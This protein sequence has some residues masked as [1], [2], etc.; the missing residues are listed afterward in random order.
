MAV[1]AL[2]GEDEGY[3]K[4]SVGS[5]VDVSG[6]GVTQSVRWCV[7]V[8]RCVASRASADVPCG[9]RTRWGQVRKSWQERASNDCQNPR[10]SNCSM[11]AR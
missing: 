4:R 1:R 8:W 10:K 7:R 11:T 5:L 3:R 6:P 9:E 2:K